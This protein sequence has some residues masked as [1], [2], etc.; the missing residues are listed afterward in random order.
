MPLPLILKKRPRLSATRTVATRVS[1]LT[2]AKRGEVPTRYITDRDLWP[3][4]D[5]FTPDL[6]KARVWQY[7]PGVRRWVKRNMSALPLLAHVRRVWVN[8][9]LVVAAR[10][11]AL[12]PA[13]A[14]ALPA[15]LTGAELLAAHAAPGAAAPPELPVPPPAGGSGSSP[16]RPRSARSGAIGRKPN[17]NKRHP[18]TP[19]KNARQTHAKRPAGPAARKPAQRRKVA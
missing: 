11:V 13:A 6:G 5:L 12:R 18:R 2:D 8:A 10:A 1:V 7:A 15:P 19:G 3:A 14:E 16:K 9:E 4:D 17:P